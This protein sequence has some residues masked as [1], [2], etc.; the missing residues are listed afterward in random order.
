M[1]SSYPT[2]KPVAVLN[3]FW[4]K[5]FAVASMLV[6]HVGAVLF[7]QM[8]W[9]RYIGRLAFPIFVFLLVE[10][11]L[12]TQNVRRYELRLLLFA[13]I[14][15]IP[16]DLAFNGSKLEF[17]D[18]NVF[19]TLLIGLVMLDV[20]RNVREKYM[21]QMYGYAL[22]IGIVI[23]FALIAF[24]LKTDYSAA[25][26]LIIYC[27]YRFRELHILKYTVFAILCFAF[28]GLIEMPACLAV[29]LLLLYNGERGLRHGRGIYDNVKRGRAYQIT[30]YAFYVFYP[31]H[32][33]VLH[34]ISLTMTQTMI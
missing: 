26:I 20:I 21:P 15:E 25:G 10:G 18:Q 3:G 5:I 11:F 28:F 6:D 31:A 8:M 12:N 33:L 16:F 30:R 34:F 19:F 24:W 22:E 2:I 27:F 7:P 4:L 17:Y 29:A 1:K 23:V 13:L 14:S 9:L 32:L